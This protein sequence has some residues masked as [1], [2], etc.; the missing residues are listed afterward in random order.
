MEQDAEWKGVLDGYL[1]SFSG[2]IRDKRTSKTFEEVIKGV[3]ASGSLICE[4]IAAHSS[5]LSAAKEG[6][7]RVIRLATGEST[8]RSGID[9]ENITARQ[10]ERAVSELKK[11]EHRS[12]G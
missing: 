3:I 10:R 2:I 7:Q 1:S 4:R 8:I 6:A 9:A 5:V 12:C 11:Q